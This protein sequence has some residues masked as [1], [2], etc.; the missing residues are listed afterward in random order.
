MHIAGL[1]AE[2]YEKRL[3]SQEHLKEE[4]KM[5]IFIKSNS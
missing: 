4:A 5:E 2:E 3:V 1:N